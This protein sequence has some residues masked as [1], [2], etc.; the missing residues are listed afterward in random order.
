MDKGFSSS[1]ESITRVMKVVSFGSTVPYLNCESC[2]FLDQ[3]R[4]VVEPGSDGHCYEA[5]L[6]N[7]G[8]PR[9]QVEKPH[10]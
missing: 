2:V 7:C 9:Q 10:L 6:E 4:E 5:Y 1:V 8:Y 3:F